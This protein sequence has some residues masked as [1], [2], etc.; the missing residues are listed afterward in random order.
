M[1]ITSKGVYGLVVD[2]GARESLLGEDWFKGFYRDILKPN[3]LRPRL[4]RSEMK[5]H[6]VG[7]GT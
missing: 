3:R 1:A 6:G 4:R 2:T 7:K 5:F